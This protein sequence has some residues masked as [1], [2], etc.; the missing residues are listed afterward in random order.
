M[1][2]A[3]SHAWLATL[4][5]ENTGLIQVSPHLIASLK[6]IAPRRRVGRLRLPKVLAGALLFTLGA[7][8]CDRSVRTFVKERIRPESVVVYAAPVPEEERQVAKAAPTP[9]PPPIQPS[10]EY[11]KPGTAKS[12]VAED[13]PVASK[14]APA[15]KARRSP[16]GKGRRS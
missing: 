5:P 10:V 15:K 8:A 2:D 6:S 4:E 16:T 12:V 1:L 14:P 13:L 11:A 7:L 9:P 3:P